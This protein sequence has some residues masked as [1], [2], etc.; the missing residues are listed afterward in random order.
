MLINKKHSEIF[1]EPNRDLIRAELSAIRPGDLPPAVRGHREWDKIADSSLKLISVEDASLAKATRVKVSNTIKTA[2][3]NIK[4]AD[5][6][7]IANDSDI[8]PE[9]SEVLKQISTRLFADNMTQQQYYLWRT[10]A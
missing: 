8:T 5:A 6:E 9:N 2:E 10:Y 7:L 4:G 1:K 3:R